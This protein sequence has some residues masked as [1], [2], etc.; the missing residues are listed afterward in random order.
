MLANELANTVEE[1]LSIGTLILRPTA[2]IGIAIYDTDE[3]SVDLLER[4]D[5]AMIAAKTG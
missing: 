4:A 1:P 2:S 3:S 5:R